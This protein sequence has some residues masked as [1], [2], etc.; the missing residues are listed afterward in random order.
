[1]SRRRR[2]ERR[3]VQPDPKFG[4]LLFTRFINRLMIQGK[5]SKAESIFYGALD[6]VAAKLKKDIDEALKIFNDAIENIRPTME[7]K[8]RRVGGAT[9]QVPTDVR[10]DRSVDLAQ[11]WLISFARARSDKTM[12]ARLAS[13]ILDAAQNRGGA[14]KKREETHKMAEA[15][16][17]FAHLKWGA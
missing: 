2:A 13:E 8:S 3:E 6:T 5:R 9:Y 17:A 10:Y 1:M 15:N 12:E 4:N 14:V 11:R 16:R 7:L